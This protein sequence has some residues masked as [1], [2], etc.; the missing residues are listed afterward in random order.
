MRPP[1]YLPLSLYI[2]EAH[3]FISASLSDI[4]KE[5]RKYKLSCVLATQDFAVIEERMARVMLNVGNIISYRLGN[6]E[7]G[8]VA[9]EL[10]IPSQDIQ[11][12]EKYHVAYLT[13][14]SR[15]IAKAPRPPFILP[16][17]PPVAVPEPVAG[18]QSKSKPSWFTMESYQPA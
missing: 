16:K 10:D 6:R 5:G 4:L 9:R 8:F 2:D 1:E 11:F 14:K 7:A 12:I 15:G 13:P 3:N 18:F 17:E